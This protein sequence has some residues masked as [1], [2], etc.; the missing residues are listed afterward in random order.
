[1]LEGL[2]E[3][4]TDDE[5]VLLL[6]LIGAEMEA[7]TSLGDEDRA[8][9]DKLAS[10]VEGYD[11]EELSQAVQS[12]V[13]SRSQEDQKLAWPELKRRRRKRSSSGE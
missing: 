1:M 2:G 7:G 8:A 13:T 4:L 3:E 9:L 11:T 12:M 5:R 10:L 6:A